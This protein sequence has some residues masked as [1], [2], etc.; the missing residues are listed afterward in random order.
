[1][2]NETEPYWEIRIYRS[3]G[4]CNYEGLPYSPEDLALIEDL[5]VRT[6]AMQVAAKAL[7]QKQTKGAP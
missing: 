6:R 2:S 7:E 1:M 4:I 5:V 3:K